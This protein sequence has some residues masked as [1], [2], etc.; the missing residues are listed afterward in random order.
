MLGYLLRRILV[1]VPLWIAVLFVTFML[2]HAIPGGPFDTGALRSPEAT[3]VLEEQYH[4]DEPVWQ[5]F[6]RYLGGVLRGDMGE[7]MVRQGVTVA[8]TLAERVPVSLTLGACALAVAVSVGM[9]L[10]ILAAVRANRFLDRLLM[11][12]ATAAYAIPSFVLALLLMLTFGLRLGWLPLGGWGSPSQAVLPALALGLPWSGLLAR[13]TRAA[14]LDVLADDHIRTARAKGAGPVGV[15]LGHAFP[16]A[17]IPLTTVVALL[18]AEL[19]V[20]SVV[21]EQIFGIP[22]VGQ[23]MVDSV[24][25]SDYTMTLGVIVFYA[26]TIFLAN[27]AADIAYAVIDPRVRIT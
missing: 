12:G 2:I 23:T 7:S 20:G 4:L 18:A 27:L 6:V 5:Q 21:V 24:L 25:G 15:V 9:P 19:I 1:I 16:N 11:V 22:G 14:M 8:D 13:M 26:T 10:G 17:L 3:A